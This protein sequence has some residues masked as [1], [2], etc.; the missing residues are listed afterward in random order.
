MPRPA[1]LLALVPIALGAALA[2]WLIA[3][4]PGP[5]RIDGA[6]PALAVRVA[7]VE[8]ADLQ[9]VVR[10]WGAVRAA[11]TWTAAAEVRGQVVW[12]HPDL[13]AGRLI[14]AGTEVLRID[15]ADYALAIA[16]AEADLMA[17]DAEA[18]QIATEAENTGRVLA[19][20][21]DRLRL[22]EADLV[23]IRDL[24][25]QGANP[26]ARADE[27]ERA[28]LQVR[29]TVIEL[30]NAL[31]LIP[32][33]EARSAAQRARTQAALARAQR[34]LDHTVLVAPFALRVTDVAVDLFQPVSL[35]QVLIRGDGLERAEVVV[36][37]PLPAF[38][39]L[40]FP[41]DRS[42]DPLAALR[43]GPAARLA[44]RL[45]P[46]SDPTQVWQAEVTRIEGAL[47]PRARSV[48]VVVS[49]ARPYADAAPPLRMPLVPNLQVEV[50]LTGPS[51]AGV[52]TIPESALHGGHV[53][54]ATPDDRL[55]LRP[56]SP[57]FRQDG[58]VVIRDGL[59]EGERL[60]LDDIAPALPGM[61]LN[62]V[63]AVP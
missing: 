46:L 2:A 29:R 18:R 3:N 58:R 23:R 57:A 51:L 32:S 61:A 62:P 42:G 40:L 50:T 30:R 48:P 16:Q 1:A 47:D 49:V 54:L 11:E 63:P 28:V 33:R 19:L 25:A 17:L 56:V 7:P 9:P 8:R 5:A 44:A 26:Q 59:A 22:A 10:G 13:E 37:V 45:H 14:A 35:G 31:S 21:E 27:A 20:E 55:E 53:Y 12:R 41:F 60:V 6:P 34:D 36:Q 15:P 43:E 38:Q 24:V 4:A 39:R 52:V